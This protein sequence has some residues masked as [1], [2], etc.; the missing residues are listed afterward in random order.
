MVDLHCHSCCSDGTDTPEDLARIAA[1]RGLSA[2]VLTDHDTCAGC[3]RF[4]AAAAALGVRSVRGMELSADVPDHTVHLL[5][6]GFDPE[7]AA[8][9]D[10]VRRVRDGRAE[11]NEAILG[12]LAARGFPVTMD[13]VRAE[14]DGAAVIARP[15]IA[16][17]LVKKGY[18]RNRID[19]FNRFLAHGAFAYTE[20]FRLSPE[21]CI[22]LVRAAGGV[23]SLAHPMQT[24]FNRLRLRK[25]VKRLAEAGLAGIEVHYPGHQP[26]VFR[27]YSGLAREFGLVV[28]GGS[29]Y[30]GAN[31]PG[32]SLGTAYG[33][34]AVPDSC[35]DALCERIGRAGG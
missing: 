33:S 4:I 23:V 15:H 30:H 12:K 11:R 13:E 1:A 25:F 18:A 21:E 2:V 3:D 31:H 34:L 5:A 7:N 29:D 16:R 14:A 26:G 19:A 28:T 17:A 9:A 10:A 35:F 24:R 32:V 27:E 6:Y 22:E 8:L 20:R